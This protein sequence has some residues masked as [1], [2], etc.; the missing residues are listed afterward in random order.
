[1]EN[2]DPK[3]IS[4]M[5]QPRKESIQLVHYTNSEY[6]QIC[7]TNLKD[8]GLVIFDFNKAPHHKDAPSCHI[9]QEP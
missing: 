6:E 9:F 8:N 4:Q 1:M 2:L 7:K 5:L 3:N